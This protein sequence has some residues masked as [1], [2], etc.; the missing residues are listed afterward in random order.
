MRLVDT[1]LRDIV[2]STSLGRQIFEDFQRNVQQLSSGTGQG[3]QRVDDDF[4]SF[5]LVVGDDAR[6]FSIL[7]LPQEPAANLIQLIN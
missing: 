7:K 6:V 2:Q 4:R 5:M 3:F 1:D